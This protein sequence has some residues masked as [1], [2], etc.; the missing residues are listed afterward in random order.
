MNAQTPAWQ[1]YVPIV[2]CLI[3][4]VR[5][6]ERELRARLMV[7]RDRAIQVRQKNDPSWAADQLLSTIEQLGCAYATGS[8][9]VADL[10]VVR[11]SMADLFRLAAAL[12]VVGRAR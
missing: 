4:S 3:P 1:R 8:L 11:A 12:E 9:D 2:D 6:D 7:M 5:V 10:Q